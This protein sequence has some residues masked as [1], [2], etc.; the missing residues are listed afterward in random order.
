[1]VEVGENFNSCDFVAVWVLNPGAGL[2]RILVKVEKFRI[3]LLA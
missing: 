1:M 3:H 2:Q